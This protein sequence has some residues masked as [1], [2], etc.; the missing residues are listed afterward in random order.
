MA[1]SPHD[2]LKFKNSGKVI[3]YFGMDT[4]FFSE[5][6]KVQVMR[7]YLYLKNIRNIIQNRQILLLILKVRKNVHDKYW[8]QGI[9]IKVLLY[10]KVLF[11]LLLL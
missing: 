10:L 9:I 5:I 2:N 6:N 8:S 7:Q 1:K 11:F 3:N 4:A